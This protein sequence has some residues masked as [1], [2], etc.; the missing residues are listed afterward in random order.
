MHTINPDPEL[1]KA[2]YHAMRSEQQIKQT[3][4]NK[5]SQA[6]LHHKKDLLFL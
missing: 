5:I 4:A 1:A 2:A 3:H 6:N